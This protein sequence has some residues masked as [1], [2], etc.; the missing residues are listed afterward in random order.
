MKDILLNEHNDLRIENGDFVLGESSL[1]HQK[2]ILLAQKGEYKGHPEVGAGLK[3]IYDDENP[4]Q[5]LRE[6]KRQMEYDGMRVI[7]LKI[8]ALG[9]LILKAFYKQ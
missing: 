7:K 1:Q 5:V 9:K 8:N 4:L 2:H 3:N 6:I